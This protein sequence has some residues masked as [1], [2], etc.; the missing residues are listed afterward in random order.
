MSADLGSASDVLKYLR[1]VTFVCK[2]E[3]DP[4]GITQYGL[5]AEEVAEVAPD[6]ILYD[7]TGD[8]YTVRYEQLVPLLV[9]EPQVKDAE[10][11]QLRAEMNELRQLVES[12]V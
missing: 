10:I 7:D 4:I 12:V 8:P 1:P 9:D 6:L 5:I 11:E 3:I 2:R